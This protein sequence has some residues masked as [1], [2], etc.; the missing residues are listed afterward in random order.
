[1]MRIGKIE[2][3]ETDTNGHKYQ[4]GHNGNANLQKGKG[5]EDVKK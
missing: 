1:M 2:R 5:K 4:R 3:N